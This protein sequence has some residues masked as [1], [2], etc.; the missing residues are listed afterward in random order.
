MKNILQY[1]FRI[2]D[3]L[4][5]NSS[6]F[7]RYSRLISGAKL[8]IAAIVGLT[9]GDV[10]DDALDCNGCEC[11]PNSFLNFTAF[12]YVKPNLI[13]N[14]ASGSRLARSSIAESSMISS[15]KQ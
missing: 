4:S 10:G 15:S 1:N 12:P 11:R 3:K 2:S 8:A 6:Y 5:R 13:N 9:G 7:T 14:G